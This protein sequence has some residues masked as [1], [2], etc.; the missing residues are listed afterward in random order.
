MLCSIP[1]LDLTICPA[2]F[3]D[4]LGGQKEK[5][6]GEGAGLRMGIVCVGVSILTQLHVISA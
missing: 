5:I 3:G 4:A 1:A 6:R 2:G